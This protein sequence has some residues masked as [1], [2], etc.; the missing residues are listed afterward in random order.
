MHFH[1]VTK[2]IWKRVWGD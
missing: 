1:T 2:K